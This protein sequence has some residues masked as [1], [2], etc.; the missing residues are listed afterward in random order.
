[1]R[2]PLS[3][4][5]VAWGFLGVLA[6]SFT[7]PLTR[8]AVEG[9]N[10]YFVGTA[11]AVVAGVCAGALLLAVRAPL[12]CGR[13]WTG[14]AVV[15]LGVV[16][17]FPLLTS[18]ALE[19]VSASHA[20]VVIGLLPAAT[21]VVAVVRG[22]ERPSRIFWVASA[23]GAV[24]VAVFVSLGT[25]G[26]G[27]VGVADLLLAGAVIAAAFGYAEGAALSRQLGS[28]QTICWALVLALP[29]MSV[30]TALLPWPGPDAGGAQWASFA[31]LALVSM[32]LGFFAWYRSLAIGPV[33]NVSQ[34][35]L[36]QPVLTITWASTLLHEPLTPGVLLGAAAVVACAALAVTARVRSATPSV[37]APLMRARSRPRQS[38]QPSRE[39]LPKR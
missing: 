17:G 34:I 10:P 19:S 7:V 11:R 5:G 29:A 38:L 27:S 32:F 12:P 13:Q 31:Y 15:A 30:L 20:A 18:V 39:A 22:P 35:Q 4:A 33:A 37:G 6:F 23:A 2:V 24:A 9:M 36:V 14:L 25:G 3:A 1:M 21:A 26:L 8:I 16:A 28:W